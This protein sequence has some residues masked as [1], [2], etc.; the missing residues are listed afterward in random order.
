LEALRKFE[1]PSLDDLLEHVYRECGSQARIMEANRVRRGGLGG[2]F[3]RE[4]YEVLV[5]PE[6]GHGVPIGPASADEP[7]PGAGAGP[8]RLAAAEPDTVGPA[9]GRADGP[10]RGRLLDLVDA[11]EGDEL[12]ADLVHTDRSA[13]ALIDM[14]EP[15]VPDEAPMT[16]GSD[17]ET[18]TAVRLRQLVAEQETRSAQPLHT[19][20][21]AL[22]EAL[23]AQSG[24]TI[25]HP[26][27]PPPRPPDPPVTGH[28]EHAAHDDLDAFEQALLYGDGETQLATADRLTD[29]DLQALLTPAPGT[30]PATGADRDDLDRA[31][32]TLLRELRALDDTPATPVTAPPEPIQ[33]TRATGPAP[34]RAQPAEVDEPGPVR[35]A[36][37]IRPRTAPPAPVGTGPLVVV[38]ALERALADAEALVAATGR[39]RLVLAERTPAPGRSV[40]TCVRTV[41]DALELIDRRPGDTD[42][43][44]VAVDLEPSPAGLLWARRILTA[45]GPSSVALSVRHDDQAEDVRATVSLLGGVDALH[46]RSTDQSVASTDPARVD[47]GAP[48][49]TI[50]G[51]AMTAEH[52]PAT[53]TMSRGR[54][55]A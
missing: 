40:A 6:P 33:P 42:R 47:L 14:S 16:P 55:G 34:A 5:E 13:R 31:A 39:A 2:F 43:L 19:F 3:A 38:G 4:R 46:V 1:G 52:P 12:L 48:I 15:P 44:V 41:E 36:E 8:S 30:G 25:D 26:A 50:D 29:E 51:H 11:D 9:S 23:A 27:S 53:P 24:L 7:P 21:E 49:A 32:L 22:D 35:T 20:G 37:T 18:P 54:A 17:D 10:S 28:E 45:L